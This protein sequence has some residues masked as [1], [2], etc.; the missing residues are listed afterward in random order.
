MGKPHRRT[1]K[2]FEAWTDGDADGRGVAVVSGLSAG[3]L[4]DADDLVALHP[5]M[6]QDWLVRFIRKYLRILFLVLELQLSL[7]HCCLIDSIS[8]S[9]F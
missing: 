2:T 7:A 8:S 9:D 4:E 6:E 3:R 5:P 1:V